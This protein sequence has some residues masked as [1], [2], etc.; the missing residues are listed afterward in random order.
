[1]YESRKW[2]FKTCNAHED[3]IGIF[4]QQKSSLQI[5]S[6][7]FQISFIYEI[8]SK[9]VQI[10]SYFLGSQDYVQNPQPKD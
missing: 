9:T 8:P 2:L 4:Q 10:Q 3:S 5:L 6:H 7:T 1:M